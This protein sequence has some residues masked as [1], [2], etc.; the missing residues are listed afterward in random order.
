MKSKSSFTNFCSIV[1]KAGD[2]LDRD[3]EMKKKI[4]LYFH[5]VVNEQKKVEAHKEA[6]PNALLCI[7][8]EIED[9]LENIINVGELTNGSLIFSKKRLLD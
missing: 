6:I 4:D 8:D 2:S 1:D 7:F 9:R 5:K 3:D